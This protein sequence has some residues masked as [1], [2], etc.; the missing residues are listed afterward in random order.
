MSQFI[1]SDC[2]RVLTD[3]ERHYYERRCEQCER[4]EFERYQAWRLGAEDAE[5]DAMWSVPNPV[6]H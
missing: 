1:C 3:E 4:D 5:L 6:R 2:G